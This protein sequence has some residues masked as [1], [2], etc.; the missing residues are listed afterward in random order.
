[1]LELN[2]VSVDYG[3][4]KAV[5]SVNLR[6]NEGEVVA[7]L[8]PN[9]AG[10]TSLI[11]AVMGIV[12]VSSGNIRFEGRDVTLAPPEEKVRCG[13]GISPEGRRVF[14][15]LTVAENL[16]LG[17]SAQPDKAI[18]AEQLTKYLEM[19][20]ILKERYHQKAGTL[21]GG[22][23]QQL[24]ISRCLMSRPRIVMLDEPSL[25]LAPVIVERIFELIAELKASGLT[26][27]LVEQN[28]NEAL[29]VA[30]RAYLLHSGRLRFEGA[31]Q[32]LLNSHDLMSHYMGLGEAQ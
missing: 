25:G 3:A 27:L 5:Q 20:P 32:E 12:Q 1:M 24:A 11:S 26:I 22:E 2:S 28:A 30:D 21:S 9:G 23:Q 13:I 18:R 16:Q 6:V 31:A 15:N 8:G 10:K 17:G 19:F 14:A 29:S 7:L 4:V